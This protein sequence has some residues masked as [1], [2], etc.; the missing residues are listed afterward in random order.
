[1]DPEP[2]LMFRETWNRAHTCGP[3]KYVQGPSGIELCLSK[4]IFIA[5]K[6]DPM[7]KQLNWWGSSLTISKVQS[8]IIMMGSMACR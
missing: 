6:R 7:T 5:V 8:I 4:G 1:M 2:L 3:P